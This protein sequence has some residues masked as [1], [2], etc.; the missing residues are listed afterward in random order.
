LGNDAYTIMDVVEAQD[1]F[2][3]SPTRPSYLVYAHTNMFS[4]LQNVD[5]FI[6]TNNYPSQANVN[7]SEV[8][9]VSNGRFFISSKGSVIPNASANGNDVYNNIF[10]GLHS[11]GCIEQDQYSAQFIYRPP[12]FSGP[13]ALNSTAAVKFAEVSRVLYDAWI[14]LLRATIA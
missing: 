6:S 12:I 4:S 7:S 11:Y 5:T 9:A 3:T 2:G 14:V 1:K 8:G 10:V 13:E